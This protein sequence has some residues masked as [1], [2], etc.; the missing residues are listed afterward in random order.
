MSLPSFDMLGA[1]LYPVLDWFIPPAI[2]AEMELLRRARMFLISHLFGPFL[3]HTI[4]LYVLF[5]DPHPDAAWYAFFGI[6][7]AFWVFPFALKATGWYVPLA[8][9]SVENL[10]FTILWGCYHYGGTSSPLIPWVIT[11]PL[12][13]FFYLGSGT[14]VRAFVLS[15]IVVNLAAFY[16][17]YSLGNG[18]PQHVPLEQLSGLGIVSMVCAA[19]Y[20]AMMALYYANIVNSQSELERE[21]KRRMETA[22]QLRGATEEAHRAN[23]GKSEFLAKMS[24]ELRTPLN[25]VIGYSAVLLDEMVGGGEAEDDRRKD[26]KKIHNAGKRLLKLITDLLDFSK[27]EAGKMDLFLEPTEMANLIDGIVEEFQ[28]QIAESGNKVIVECDASLVVQVDQIKLRRTIADLLGNALKATMDGKIKI[29][30][31]A[32]AEWLRIAVN[33]NGVG[34]D[35]AT[36][37]LLFEAFKESKEETSSKYAEV[38]LGLPVS[39]RLCHLMGGLI[40]A[41][42]T[43]GRG[44]SFTI[45]LPMQEADGSAFATN[46]GTFAPTTD[47]IQSVLIIDDDVAALELAHQLIAA[48]GIVPLVASSVADGLLLLQTERPGLILLDVL[49]PERDGWEMLDLLKGAQK[50]SDCPVVMLT[51][52]DDR[53]RSMALGA[54]AHIMKPLTKSVLREAL[55]VANMLAPAGTNSTNSREAA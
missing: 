26:L 23:Q 48:E 36:L 33:D 45:R 24:H 44:S 39:Q 15:I 43:P 40:T 25:A 53:E 38:G 19:G 32:D 5:I 52:D 9:M 7:T 49:M 37:P 46:T 17:I 20:V 22:N 41:V 28:E 11:V 1:K 31:T 47:G 54:D 35:P 10:I 2:K 14:A 4:S 51:G 21:V 30:V 55:R 16:A 50:N 12:L 8:L 29:A 3:G 34:I 42:S 27:L 18:F 13:A 6:I